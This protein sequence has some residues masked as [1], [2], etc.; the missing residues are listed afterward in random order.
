MKMGVAIDIA[1]WTLATLLLLASAYG[2]WFHFSV[3]PAHG[4]GAEIGL[5]G[6]AAALACILVGFV[7]LVFRVLAREPRG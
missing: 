7:R 3:G 5:V 6:A 2:W 4:V 1:I